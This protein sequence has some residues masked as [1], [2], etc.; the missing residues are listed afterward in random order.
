M[1][2][3]GNMLGLDWW[4]ELKLTIGIYKNMYKPAFAVG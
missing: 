2:W 4:D 1:K 3:I